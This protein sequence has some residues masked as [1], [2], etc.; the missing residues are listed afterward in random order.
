MWAV[1]R[2]RDRTDSFSCDGRGAR[3]YRRD[4]DRAAA[5]LACIRAM[6]STC[7]FPCRCLCQHVGPKLRGF[8]LV[9]LVLVICI[10]AVVA[11][12]A[13]PRF[14]NSLMRN[15]VE[16]AARR[17]VSDLSFA[18]RHA[19]LASASQPVL[20]GSKNHYS[21]PGLADPDHP[22]S[23]YEVRLDEPPYEVSIRDVN[24]GDDEE[25]VFDAYGV[26]NTG[27]SLVVQ[28][29]DHARMISIAEGTGQTTVTVVPP[30]ADGSQTAD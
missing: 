21:L 25:I 10:M 7:Y 20:F 14:A 30:L 26:P 2:R 13:V 16:A 3:C 1:L 4:G 19:R 9:E 5:R 29:G 22:A 27:G 28:A 23:E 11:S 24:L 17:I 6:M 12:M 8:S 15:R 18:Q